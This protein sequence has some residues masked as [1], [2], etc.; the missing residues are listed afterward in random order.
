MLLLCAHDWVK[1]PH[2]Y[3][4]LDRVSRAIVGVRE[5]SEN[6]AQIRLQ[7]MFFGCLELIPSLIHAVALDSSWYLYLDA[8]IHSG[9][10]IVAAASHQP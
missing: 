2:T 10:G 9:E 1:S 7:P 5:R 4:P 6:A 8:H 3:Y